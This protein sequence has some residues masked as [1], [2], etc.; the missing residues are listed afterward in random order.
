M[1]SVFERQVS[2]SEVRALWQTDV[3]S[4]SMS[5]E[6]YESIQGKTHNAI[7]G[8]MLDKNTP[9]TEE[10]LADIYRHFG[11]NETMGRQFPNEMGLDK[12]E[13]IIGAVKPSLPLPPLPS[14]MPPSLPL[15]PNTS[16]PGTE[17]WA[18]LRR[19]MPEDAV[20]SDQ[21]TFGSQPEN[22]SP[23][24]PL[25]E[26]APHVP[27]DAEMALSVARIETSIHRYLTSNEVVTFKSL[28]TLE[29]STSDHETRDMVIDAENFLVEEMTKGPLSPSQM[30]HL[31]EQYSLQETITVVRDADLERELFQRRP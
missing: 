20:L 9:L 27:T 5:S 14:E 1:N 10:E 18:K 23:R 28:K 17:T 7:V 2:A 15:P 12:N 3:P 31:L 8:A 16:T 24:M 6:Y 26:V 13:T 22:I 11:Y 4:S 25:N 19:P 21:R 30:Y 29:L